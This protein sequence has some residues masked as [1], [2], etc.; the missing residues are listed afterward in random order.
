VLRKCFEDVV[1]RP[2]LAEDPGEH[3]VGVAHTVGRVFR[4]P[5]RQADGGGQQSPR[6]DRVGKHAFQPQ[7]LVLRLPPDAESTLD[8]TGMNPAASRPAT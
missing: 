8:I 6:R 2:F 3:G 5:H 4:I 1:V 7:I